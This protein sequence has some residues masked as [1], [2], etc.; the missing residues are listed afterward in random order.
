MVRW[1]V[2]GWLVWAGARL[3]RDYAWTGGNPAGELATLDGI[4]VL[5][6]PFSV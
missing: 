4:G 3:V 1:L 5:G 6:K 2:R